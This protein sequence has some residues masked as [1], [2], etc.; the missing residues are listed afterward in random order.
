[1]ADFENMVS[2]A[3]KRNIDI[4]LDMVFNHCSR[5]HPYF[6]QSFN[7]F[8][9]ENETENSK[10]DWFNWSRERGD[11]TYSGVYYEAKFDSSMPDFNLDNEAVRDELEKVIK[12]W[13]EKGV[14]GFR[15]DAVLYYYSSNLPQN[16]KFLNWIKETALKYDPDFYMVGEAWVSNTGA[17]GYF[18]SKCDSFFRFSNAMGGDNT[19]INIAKGYGDTETF[20]EQIQMEEKAIKSRNPNGYSSYFLSNHDQDRVSK[21]L[22]A[23]QNKIAASIYCLMPG[24]PYMYYGEEISLVGVRKTSPEDYSDVKR[25]LPMVWSGTD[26]KGECIFPE[27]NRPDLNTTEQVSIGVEEQLKDP[28]SL[29]NHYR[30]VV[31]IRNKYPLLKHGTFT[32][33]YDLLD[34]DDLHVLAYKITLGDDYIYV[35]HNLGNANVK[36][37]S[38][39]AQILD[40]INTTHKLPKIEGG[41]L[42]LG[43]GSSV[44]IK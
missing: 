43:N 27:A 22:S 28:F 39:G 6:T 5:Q 3:A 4:M 11:A 9:N 35:V 14:K 31:N 44:I 7:D 34:T 30:Y 42:Y 17:N 8:I 37:T 36:V 25:R 32:S 38:P 26:K 1:M 20:A 19:F 40:S 16:V 21:N 29:L 13:I 18:S 33:A 2:E 10:K 41:E 12:F 15:L 23:E 24:T